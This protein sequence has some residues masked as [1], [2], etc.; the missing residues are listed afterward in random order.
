MKTQDQNQ[1]FKAA[2]EVQKNSYSPYSGHKIGAAL[3]LKS[4]QIFS[5]CNV[6]N[7]SYGATICAE[8]AAVLKAVSEV[9]SMVITQICVVSD[10]S[11]AWPPCGM[12]LQVLAEFATSDTEV[13]LAT[14]AGVQR[15]LSF[16]ALLPHGFDAE[17]L[18]SS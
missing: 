11:Q 16:S 2:L 13:I 14:P 17:F 15:T 3:R 5:G 4:G 10:N 7:A 8:R 6:E 12:C 18:Q 1:L 9:G